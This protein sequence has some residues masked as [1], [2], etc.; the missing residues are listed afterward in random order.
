MEAEGLGWE[1]SEM[2]VR[3]GIME[4]AEPGVSN[5]PDS[6]P[7]LHHLCPIKLISLSL[8]LLTHKRQKIEQYIVHEVWKS[9]K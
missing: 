7:R 2:P 5:W 4:G 8:N 9:T 3:E 1:D 6:K